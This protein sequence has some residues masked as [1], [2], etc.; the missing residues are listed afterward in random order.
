M[1]FEGTLY[2]FNNPAQLI[3]VGGRFSQSSSGVTPPPRPFRLRARSTRH[4]R[5][6]SVIP[7]AATSDTHALGPADARKSRDN[8]AGS[9]GTDV[10]RTRGQMIN[11]W[12]L[13]G[14]ALALA[15]AAAYRSRRRRRLQ[16]PSG[17][18]VASVSEQWLA[19]RRTHTDDA[20]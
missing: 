4:R 6:N 12:L 18:T 14:G 3:T 5:R 20:P 1:L 16:V 17:P 9:T 19:D 11:L 2:D 10:A 15:V 13:A 8:P 7:T